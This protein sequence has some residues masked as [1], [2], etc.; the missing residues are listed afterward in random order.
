MPN[1]GVCSL[2]VLSV[3]TRPKGGSGNERREREHTPLLGLLLKWIHRLLSVGT[4]DYPSAVCFTSYNLLYSWNILFPT[5]QNL[6]QG[7]NHYLNEY[8]PS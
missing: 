7:K 8:Y 2:T 5:P 4:E 3:Q 6:Y 1:R